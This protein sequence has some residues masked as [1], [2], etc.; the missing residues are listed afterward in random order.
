MTH[1]CDLWYS[2]WH[3][4]LVRRM[5][6][7][8]WRTHI[9][10]SLMGNTTNSYDL[11]YAMWRDLCSC[12]TWLIHVCYDSLIW[13]TTNLCVVCNMTELIHVTWMSHV[14]HEWVLS[15]HTQMLHTT[16]LNESCLTWMTSAIWHTT[17]LCVTCGMQHDRTHSCETW[18]IHVAQVSFVWHMT[19]SC[20]VAWRPVIH[21]V[22]RPTHFDIR[23]IHVRHDS[24]RSRQPV[25]C[26]DYNS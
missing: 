24:F 7:V 9:T 6:N 16:C 23:L 10:H 15:C 18:I 5:T 20:D 21:N 1:A 22:T 12:D 3:D 14:S 2:T 13:H 26:G 25:L 4:L 11:W 17:N 19:H 8:S